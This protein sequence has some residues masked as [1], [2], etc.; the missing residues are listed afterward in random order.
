MLGLWAQRASSA[1]SQKEGR[2]IKSA[3]SSILEA[4]TILT[5]P[6]QFSCILHSLI[7][8]SL[9]MLHTQTHTH[10]HTHTHSHTH[11]YKYLET[12]ENENSVIQNLWD[13][14]KA[15]P[16]GKFIAIQTYLRKPEKLK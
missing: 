13:A 12:N 5:P 2:L 15:V 9:N 6:S 16:R 11:V 10:T 1:R 3:R 8:S 7:G 14:A 4:V